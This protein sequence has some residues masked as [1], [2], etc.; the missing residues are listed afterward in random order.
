[1][2][3]TFFGHK[4]CSE[5]I[6]GKIN[7][8]LHRL[9][10]DEN[11]DEFLVGNQG[12]FDIKIQK[13]LIKIKENYPH[14]RYSVVLAYLPKQKSEDMIAENTVFPEILEHVPPKYAIDR[15]DTWMLVKSDFVVTFVRHI[16]GGAAKFREKAVKAG[17]TVIDL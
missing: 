6:S 9:I 17:K 7:E 10:I 15:C 12:Q 11:V 16:T 1:M 2:I 5:E 13:A 3:C 4:D 8:T 14:I